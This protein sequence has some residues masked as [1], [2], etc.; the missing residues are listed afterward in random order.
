MSHVVFY[1]GLCGFCSR[2]TQFILAR[3]R[4]DRFRF[5][6]LQG[7][8]ASDTLRPRGFDPTDL[9]T[10]YVLTADGRV[11]SKARAALFIGRALGGWLGGVSRGLSLLPSGLLNWGYD[12]VAHSRYQL[13][14]KVD[15]CLL[16]SESER[17]KFIVG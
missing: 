2:V 13:F 10:M 11:L 3:D 14:G 9:D 15:M 17:R 7:Q 4:H 16:P 12:R 8:F 6:Q 1:D 5:A